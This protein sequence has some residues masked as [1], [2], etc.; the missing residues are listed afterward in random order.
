MSDEAT[1]EELVTQAAAK[2]REQAAEIERLKAEAA[3][4]WRQ[5]DKVWGELDA[6]KHFNRLRDSG[7]K[8]LETEIARLKLRLETYE[9]GAE[10]GLAFTTTV[11]P[12]PDEVQ[13][14]CPSALDEYIDKYYVHTGVVGESPFL[15]ALCEIRDKLRE[16]TI[17]E[18]KDVNEIRDKLNRIEEYLWKPELEGGK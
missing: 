3:H 14:T 17:D 18:E 10:S 12:K 6:L 13:V 4:A 16:L 11:E 2:L 15:A 8:R 5:K 1:V 7:L 9:R